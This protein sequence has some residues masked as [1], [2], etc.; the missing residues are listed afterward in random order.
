[1]LPDLSNFSIRTSFLESSGGSS[2]PV[3]RQQ[4]R[5]VERHVNERNRPA[6]Y[7]T[8]R[9]II[10][11]PEYLAKQIAV[12]LL[13]YLMTHGH[14]TVIV[15]LI[16]KRVMLNVELFRVTVAQNLARQTAAAV[17]RKRFRHQFVLRHVMH[18]ATDR[19]RMAA[20]DIIAQ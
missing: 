5:K 14:G 12:V 7:G 20:V 11:T 13:L 15:P 6:R 18:V 19:Q 8:A 10:K 16:L 3:R 1:M 2:H 4:T 9:C 17:R